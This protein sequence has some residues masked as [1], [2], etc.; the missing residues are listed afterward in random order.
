[1][2]KLK[3]ILLLSCFL[4]A[5]AIACGEDKEDDEGDASPDGSAGTDGDSDTDSDADTDTDSDTDTDTGPAADCTGLDDFTLCVVDTVALPN[6]DLSYDICVNEAC[7]S[8]GSCD[9]AS[10]NV[11]GPHFPLPDTNLRVCYDYYTQTTCTSFP[12][13][14]DGSP[15]LCGQDGQY[16]WDVTHEASERFTRD[17]STVDQP[18]VEDSV[19]GLIWQGC[20]NGLTGDNCTGGTV[21]TSDWYTALAD[22]DGLDWGGHMDWRLPDPHE[23][24]TLLD[25]GK[26]AAPAI[27]VTAF[28]ETPN[29]YFWSSSSRATAAS[30]AWEVGFDFGVVTYY[31]KSFDRHVRCVRGEPV[32]APTPRFTRDTTTSGQPTVLDTRTGLE[33]Q[34]CALGRTGDDC[35]TVGADEADW[36]W[37]LQYCEGLDWGDDT[38]WRLPNT[39]ELQ[40]IVDYRSDS[41]SIDETAFP[42]TSDPRFWSSS[43][44]GSTVANGN[45]SSVYFDSGGLYNDDKGDPNHV[46]CV[47]A[48]S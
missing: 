16:G 40:S 46:R 24:S 41:P 27:D 44:L 31:A 17:S 10:C 2:L 38:D 48:G 39:I 43:S 36:G 23:L 9:D 8:P 21:D 11:P 7:I 20:A 25:R 30:D 28:P 42:E 34:G 19:S 5:F 6:G 15:I 47:R 12:C 13:N 26:T 18:I 35:K 1:M 37:A 14:T 33:W 29:S 45:A 22:C 32:A 3:L 4:C